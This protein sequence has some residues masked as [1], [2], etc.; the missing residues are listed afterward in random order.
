MFKG[1]NPTSIWCQKKALMLIFGLYFS[2]SLLSATT[3]DACHPIDKAALLDFKSKITFD[4]S[5][6]LHTPTTDCCKSWQGIAC[7]NSGR[8]VNVSR[9]GLITDNFLFDTSMSG[10]LSPFLANISYLQLL[11][12][13]NLKDLKGRIPSELGKLSRL[14]HL[15]LDTNKLTGSIPGKFRNLYNLKKLYLSDNLL[16]GT[17]PFSIF[18]SLTSLSELG[19]SGNKLSG[20]IPSSIEKLVSLT[21]FD[22]HQNFFSGSIP[23]SIGNLKNLENVDFSYNQLTGKIPQ[24]I[25]GLSNLVWLYLNHNQLTG[26]IPASISGLVSLKSC[27]L[28]ENKL[29]GNIA[30]SIGNLR[31]IQSLTFENNKL[32]GKLPATIGHLSRLTGLQSLDLSFNP[33]GLVSIPDWFQELKLFRLLLGNTGL[34]GQLPKWLASSSISI[35]DLSDNGLTENCQIG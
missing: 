5:K 19:L 25:G 22:I 2:A 14:T 26:S 20:P 8:V 15:F 29:T 6:L 18:E 33:L 12:L 35:L 32:T 17:V 28:S 13:S 7:D 30:A 24:S 11:D 4:P 9:S 23:E 31:S 34:K 21:K 16:S 10:T 1:L 27:V 3:S